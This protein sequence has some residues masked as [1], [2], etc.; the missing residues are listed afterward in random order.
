MP[1]LWPCNDLIPNQVP[2][3]KLRWGM[4]IL[5]FHRDGFG[6]RVVKPLAFKSTFIE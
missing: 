3:D 1:R 6:E 5:I 2:V 4:E